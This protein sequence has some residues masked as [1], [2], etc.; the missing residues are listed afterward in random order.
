MLSKR[1]NGY[2]MARP[3]SLVLAEG[4]HVV[5]GTL[6]VPHVNL[7]IGSKKQEKGKEKEQ[8]LIIGGLGVENGG[9][10]CLTDI[11]VKD[12]SGQGLI[13]SGAGT[14]MVLKKVTVEKC[15]YN[16]VGVYGAKLDATGCQF[17]QNGGDGVRVRGSTTTA[18]LTN[19]TSHHN[20]YD[21][22]CASMVP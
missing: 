11:T 15:Q 12:S 1:G 2:D 17:H 9:C 13:A 22:V 4:V 6:S 3:V 18:R 7:S 8:V 10:L 21:G 20:K 5:G 19:C 14:K 16:G